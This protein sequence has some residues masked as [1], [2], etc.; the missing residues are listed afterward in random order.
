MIIK[1]DLMLKKIL[2]KINKLK[3]QKQ[4]KIVKDVL[5]AIC[6]ILKVLPTKN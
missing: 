5:V 2:L 1:E 4:L 3:Q 6:L